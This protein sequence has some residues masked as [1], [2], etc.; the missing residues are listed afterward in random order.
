MD[1]GAIDNTGSSPTIINC[2]FI[3]NA[4]VGNDGGGMNN[5]YSSSPTIVDCVFIGNSAMDWGGGIR[6]IYYSD[7]TIINCTFSENVADEGGAIFN[8]ASA[9]TITNSM[10]SDNTAWM[11]GGVY[12][13]DGSEPIITS[14]T[15]AGN[16][17]DGGRSLYGSGAVITNC[18]LWGGG[19]EGI[20]EVDGDASISYS[21]I[22]GGYSGVYNINVDPFFVDTAGGDY[23]LKSEGWR[24]DAQAES[25]VQDTVTSRCIYAGNPASSPGDE[26]INVPNDP[27]N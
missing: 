8:F 25:W 13:R 3:G 27:D 11:G 14:C 5:I 26:P 20:S 12:C 4:A 19:V 1:G 2:T 16:I 6:N 17:A 21:D 9:P 22:R 7:A 18:I 23:H 10:I 15:I 24:W